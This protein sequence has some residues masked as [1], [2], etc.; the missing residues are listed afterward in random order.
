VRI[1]SGT[2]IEAEYQ[3]GQLA[4][5]CKVD[6]KFRELRDRWVQNNP[7]KMRDREHTGATTWWMVKAKDKTLALIRAS[8]CKAPTII[9]WA[10]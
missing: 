2:Y 1:A 9:I 6:R 8:P 7:E 3:T 10:W 4:K 5:I